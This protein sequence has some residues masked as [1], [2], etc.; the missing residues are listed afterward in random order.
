MRKTLTLLLILFCILAG[1][2]AYGAVTNQVKPSATAVT[3]QIAA[4]QKI[5]AGKKTTVSVPAGATALEALRQS[6][7][8]DM[9]GSGT[10]AF[11][12][13]IDGRRAD[14]SKHEFWAFYVNGK[15]AQVGAGSH[16]LK[17]H[18]EIVWK[19]ETY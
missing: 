1:I 5:G 13:G 12:I 14:D 3:A 4:T 11:I 15:Q 16:E 9:K 7:A 8:V 17:Q 2:A 19:I 6:H 18:D 10:K